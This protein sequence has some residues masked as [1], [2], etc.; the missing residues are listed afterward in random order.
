MAQLNDFNK[1]YNGGNEISK[2]L[3]QGKVIWRKVIWQSGL[4]LSDPNLW[5]QGG[6]RNHDGTELTSNVRIRTKGY[7]EIE[8][9]SIKFKTASPYN[10]SPAYFKANGTFV[11][12]GQRSVDF[13]ETPPVGATKFRLS[14]G[15]LENVDI[16]VSEAVNANVQIQFL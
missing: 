4:D 5:E 10:V 16:V 3:H 14:I 15:N 2:V 11:S 1:I 13:T 12:F 7:Y 6:F 8:S 9:N